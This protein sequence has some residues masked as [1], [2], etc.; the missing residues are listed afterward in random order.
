MVNIIIDKMGVL[1]AISIPIFTTQLEKARE[2]VD[3]ANLRDAYAQL[4][5]AALAEETSAPS[6][7]A[8]IVYTYPTSVS[9]TSTW[10]ATITATQHDTDT[11]ANGQAVNIGGHSL[12]NPSASWTITI[13]T[14]GAV[15]WS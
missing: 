8:N 10:S 4:T 6:G 7:I 12:A 13:D 5:A 2:S 3:Q 11:W 1:V 9:S 15:T 14:D